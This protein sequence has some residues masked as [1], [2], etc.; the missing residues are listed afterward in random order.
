MQTEV[1]AELGI[2]PKM[3]RSRQRKL[4]G[5]QRSAGRPGAKA[6]IIGDAVARIRRPRSRG[7]CHGQTDRQLYLSETGG[8]VVIVPLPH[9]RGLFRLSSSELIHVDRKPSDTAAGVARAAAQLRKLVAEGVCLG[10]Q[11]KVATY[12]LDA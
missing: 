6:A 12:P 2:M 4:T 5:K 8:R 1:G 11:A 10:G 3:L 9:V 7:I